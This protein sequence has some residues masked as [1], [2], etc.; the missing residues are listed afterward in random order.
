MNVS[1]YLVL[2]LRRA[3]RCAACIDEWTGEQILRPDQVREDVKP[4]AIE[5]VGR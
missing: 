3:C 5:P 2:Y 1:R 4:V